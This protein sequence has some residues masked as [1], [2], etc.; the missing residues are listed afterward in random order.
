MIKKLISVTILALFLS[1]LLA[2][3][4]GE[5][6]A[7][8]EPLP[9]NGPTSEPSKE[10]P[11]PG[12]VQ[13]VII[14][15]ID[16]FGYLPGGSSQLNDI[17]VPGTGN[18]LVTPSGLAYT[19]S[20][21]SSGAVSAIDPHGELVYGELTALIQAYQSPQRGRA[22]NLPGITNITTSWLKKADLWEVA[23]NEHILLVGVDTE[24]FTTEVASNNIDEAM[25]AFRNHSTFGNYTILPSNK[26]VLNMSFGIVPCGNDIPSLDE[27]RKMLR[28]DEIGQF[29]EL[30][31]Y[32]A[33]QP[34]LSDLSKEELEELYNRIAQYLPRP[35]RSF[36]PELD[37]PS[38]P[39]GLE[40]LIG[41]QQTFFEE[42][43]LFK[44]LNRYTEQ[45]DTVISVGA[46]GNIDGY[47]Y[48]FAPALWDSVVSVSADYS[49]ATPPSNVTPSSNAGEVRLDGEHPN[50]PR[51]FGTSFAAPR[52][53][54]LAARYLLEGG[55]NTCYG[56]VDH[57]SP[58]L[59]YV[60]LANLSLRVWEN[61][62]L[63]D[64]VPEFC[65][66][67]PMR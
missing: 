62:S 22:Q 24:G 38:S 31:S 26:F 7:T 51:I 65:D 41:L 5:I 18:C 56:S 4:S 63:A 10:P 37:D 48:P 13:P 36:Y 6:T 9:D 16:D 1:I 21:F 54:F 12:G 19:S 29:S 50:D 66:T 58:P 44:L 17:Q 61:K 3:Q 64:A 34:A 60:S 39:D 35:I 49:R 23:P 40:S 47:L 53:S 55:N 28:Q 11:V 2:C 33:P 8:V 57:T 67:F 42:D 43:P 46:A 27:Y 32:L 14:L 59:R 52:M 15:V 30:L 45:S 20:G 25:S